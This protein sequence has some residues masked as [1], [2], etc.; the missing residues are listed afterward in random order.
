MEKVHQIVKT[1]LKN[2][3]MGL[4][5]FSDVQAY[6]VA[7]VISALWCWGWVDSRSVEQNRELRRKST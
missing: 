1:T 5:T 6:Y 2:K 3:K 7:T 4:I